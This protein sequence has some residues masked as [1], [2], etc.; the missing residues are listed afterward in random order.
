[1]GFPVKDGLVLF[2][3]R[4]GEPHRFCEKPREIVRVVDADGRA[5]LVDLHVGVVQK[6]DGFLD[7]HALKVVDRGLSCAFV[8]KGRA[9]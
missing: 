7:A 8:E 9:V 5:D 2:V 1:M 6:V 4:R 3:F